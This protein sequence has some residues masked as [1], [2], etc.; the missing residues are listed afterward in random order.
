MWTGAWPSQEIQNLGRSLDETVNLVRNP[1]SNQLD[2]V[3]RALTKFLVVRTCGFLEQVVESSCKAFL[4]SKSSP[5]AASFGSSFLG[6]GANPTPERLS[7]LLNKFSSE[8]AEQFKTFVMSDDEIRSRELSFLVDRRNKI[9][10][11][12]S[13]SVG[14][15]K[16]LALVPVARDVAD[17]FCKVL[18]PSLGA[19]NSSSWLS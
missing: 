12:Q 7:A 9:A 2:E 15:T 8:W 17:W 11:G 4:T 3:T 13:E 14:A 18:D 5:Q 16:A 1:P 19:S 10:H 6:R